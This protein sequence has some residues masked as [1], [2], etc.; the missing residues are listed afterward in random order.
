MQLSKEIGLS[1]LKLR[2]YSTADNLWADFC[3][4]LFMKW[5]DSAQSIHY[6]TDLNLFPGLGPPRSLSIWLCFNKQLALSS[7]SCPGLRPLSCLRSQLGES[8]YGHCG[9]M[10]SGQPAGHTTGSGQ[11]GLVGPGCSQEHTHA[12]KHTS[13]LQQ[14]ATLTPM[15]FLATTRAFWPLTWRE[16]TCRNFFQVIKVKVVWMQPNGIQE[17]QAEGLEQALFHLLCGWREKLP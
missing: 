7:A 16:P 8:W 6:S 9:L 4:C 1:S 5:L 14:G 12:W 2:K 15:L 17:P 11:R 13:I 3:L 10:G